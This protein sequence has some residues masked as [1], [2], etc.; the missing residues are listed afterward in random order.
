MNTKRGAAKGVSLAKRK[1]QA[2]AFD[3]LSENPTEAELKN[4]AANVAL[5]ELEERVADVRDSW[6]TDSLFEDAFEELTADPPNGN[7]GE[8]PSLLISSIASNLAPS[9]L[10]L[11]TSIISSLFA[12][13]N[14]D[15]S[16]SEAFLHLIAVICPCGSASRSCFRVILPNVATIC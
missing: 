11:Y 2:N 10:I 7:D 9:L 1:A 4:A 3:K 15:P 14:H 5:A 12:I 8:F 13:H 6:E 16:G